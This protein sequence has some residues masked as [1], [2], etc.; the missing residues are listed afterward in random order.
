VQR[1]GTSF[2]I[3]RGL[4]VPVA[5]GLRAVRDKWAQ[6]R[7]HAYTL[8][9]RDVSVRLSQWRRLG[10]GARSGGGEIRGKGRKLDTSPD[11]QLLEHIL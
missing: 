9:R 11:I 6:Q 1:Q 8:E 4:L 3:V 7:P 2:S 10:G 5:A